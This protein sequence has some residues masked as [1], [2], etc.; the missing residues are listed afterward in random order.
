M[1]MI[2]ITYDILI[3]HGTHTAPLSARDQKVKDAIFET[4][5]KTS[6]DVENWRGSVSMEETV[7]PF[8]ETTLKLSIE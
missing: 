4:I 6:D 1:I 3:Q 5:S 2:V 7:A 8:I